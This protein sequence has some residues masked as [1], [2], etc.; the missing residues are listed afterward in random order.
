[1]ELH[2]AGNSED[3]TSAF[4]RTINSPLVLPGCSC[5]AL[6]ISMWVVKALHHLPMHVSRWLSALQEEQEWSVNVGCCG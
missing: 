4:K 2:T 1:M 3:L 5:I 6:T